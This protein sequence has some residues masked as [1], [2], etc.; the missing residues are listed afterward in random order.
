MML[1]ELQRRNYSKT[2]VNVYLKI[3]AAFAEHFHRS[4]DQ[5]GPEEIR[6]QPRDRHKA[7][8]SAADNG[9]FLHSQS[10]IAS[11]SSLLP[12]HIPMTN[13]SK[14]IEYP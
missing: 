10:S 7:A 3:V 2:T 12:A 14:P 6:G 8:P 13:A 11:S 1:D 9:I 5:L 4:P